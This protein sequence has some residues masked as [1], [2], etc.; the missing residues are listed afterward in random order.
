MDEKKI[1]KSQKEFINEQIDKMTPID[2]IKFMLIHIYNNI[3]DVIFDG[4]D[5]IIKTN[6]NKM[7]LFQAINYRKEKINEKED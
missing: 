2:T 3:D 5:V 1:V 4:P 6:D 7:F